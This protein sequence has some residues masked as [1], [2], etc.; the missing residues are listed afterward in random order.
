MDYKDFRNYLT[1]VDNTCHGFREWFMKYSPNVPFVDDLSRP[2]DIQE[3]EK[4]I[5]GRIDEFLKKAYD[6]WEKSK[7]KPRYLYINHKEVDTL[8]QN[9]MLFC[10]G[11]GVSMVEV[12][13]TLIRESNL[14]EL[15]K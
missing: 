15:L 2:C 7:I 10:N 13:K 6:I 14:E 4:F 1:P 11:I 9:E 8:T 12:D 3:Y 5:N